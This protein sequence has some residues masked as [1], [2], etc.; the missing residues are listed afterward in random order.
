MV[1]AALSSALLTHQL[2]RACG[3]WRDRCF[4][5]R[6]WYIVFGAVFLVALDGVVAL[7]GCGRMVCLVYGMAM[8][9]A[10]RA[11]ELVLQTHVVCL[12]WLQAWY[13]RSYSP[14]VACTMTSRDRATF[15][16]MTRARIR[17]NLNR[18]PDP[19]MGASVVSALPSRSLTQSVTLEY[20]MT[21]S[22]PSIVYDPMLSP[23]CV[24]FGGDLSVCW[25]DC[26]G[27]KSLGRKKDGVG[28]SMS[29]NP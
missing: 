9:A 26:V 28:L 11:Y 7:S 2:Q 3:V 22:T 16:T 25:A 10:R 17:E 18:K 14:S 5:S 20:D 21:H 4:H 24:G 6:Y 19:S 1:A 12:R 23:A 15:L 8:W 29:I 13:Y 27:S